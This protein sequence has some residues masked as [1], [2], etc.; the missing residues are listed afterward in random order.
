MPLR[1]HIGRVPDRFPCR[2]TARV[3]LLSALVLAGA[4]ATRYSTAALGQYEQFEPFLMFRHGQDVE[5]TRPAYIAIITI[6]PP[7]SGYEDRPLLFDVVYPRYETDRLHFSAG[8]HRLVSRATRLMDPPGCASDEKPA[9]DGCRR[10]L[11]PGLSAG[12]PPAGLSHYLLLA[13]DEFVDPY[14]LADDLFYTALEEQALDDAL[15]SAGVE[16]AAAALERTLLDR[17]GSP[18]WA[19]LYVVAR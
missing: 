4:C 16:R 17:R 9:L 6:T 2:R 8:R 5:I 13:A 10:R 1:S 14:T 12:R 11:I 18:L 7:A 19:A 3:A 15:R